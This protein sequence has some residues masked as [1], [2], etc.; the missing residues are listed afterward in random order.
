[1][2]DACVSGLDSVSKFDF[3]RFYAAARQ[4][5]FTPRNV[6]SS[7]S[8]SGIVPFNP[9]IVFEKLIPVEDAQPG[10]P[11]EPSRA[12]TSG[13]LLKTPGDYAS[14][15]S[16]CRQLEKCIEDHGI[17]HSPTRQ[18]SK[19]SDGVLRHGAEFAIL[20]K[21]NAGLK[22]EIKAKKEKG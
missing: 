22:T 9:A 15:L 6:C 18:L 1:V 4:R 16:Y 14:L 5:A 10:T 2:E 21:E 13:D 20:Q 19:V 17:D 8:Q 3:I 7:F 12:P 11:T